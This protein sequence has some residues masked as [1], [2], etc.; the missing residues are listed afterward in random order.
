MGMYDNVYCEYPLP[1]KQVQAA[2]FQTKDFDNN[3]MDKYV[4]SE[5]GRLYFCNYEI[6]TV[7]EDERPLCKYKAKEDRTE[8]DKFCGMIEQDW[9]SRKDM[10][11]HG[12]VNFYIS[13]K[14]EWF[15]YNAKFTNGQLETIERIINTDD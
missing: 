14:E 9:K 10:N 1:E 7:P 13:Q 5:G 8:W 11:Y 15:E 4:I 12:I 3:C 2:V 6:K